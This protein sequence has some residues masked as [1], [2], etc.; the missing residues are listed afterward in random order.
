MSVLSQIQDARDGRPIY[1]SFLGAGLRRAPDAL[2][3]LSNIPEAEGEIT[4]LK[5]KDSI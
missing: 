5:E 4:A 2:P 1:G 3:A